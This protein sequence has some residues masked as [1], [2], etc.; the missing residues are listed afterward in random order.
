MSKPFKHFGALRNG[1]GFGIAIDDLDPI[2]TQEINQT[3]RDLK[4]NIDGVKFHPKFYPRNG[5]MLNAWVLPARPDVIPPMLEI[6]ERYEFKR[7]GSAERLISDVLKAEAD[8]N[9]ERAVNRQL[10]SAHDGPDVYV[11]GFVGEIRNYQRAAIDWII[12]HR[13][14]YIGDEMGTGKTL[15]ALAAVAADGSYP[16]VVVAPASVKLGWHRQ[17]Q[18]FF[19]SLVGQT[20]VCNGRLAKPIPQGT[21]IILINYDILSF[22]LT[23]LQNFKY[24]AVVLDEAHF[25][26]NRKAKRSRAAIVLAQGAEMRIAMSGTPLVSRPIDLVA[27]L[28]AL[29]RMES[30]TN[31]R[32][33]WWFIE[34]YCRPTHNGYGWDT[35][36]A[37]NLFELNERLRRNGILIRRRKEDVLTEMPPKQRVSIPL[38]ISN[39]KE[40][41]RVRN[42]ISHWVKKQIGLDDKFQSYLSGLPKKQAESEL[43]QRINE[44]ILKAEAAVTITK[45][46]ALRQVCMLGK[47]DAAMQW[48]DDFLSSEEKLVLFVS[49]RSAVDTVMSRFGSAAV[50]IMGGMGAEAKQKAIDSFINDDEVRV[51]VANIDAAA[52][53]IDGWQHVC[54]N[55]AFLE[56]T[57]TPTKH[58]QAE[59]RCHRSGQTKP[60]TC[61]YLMAN[62]TIDEYLA[63]IIDNKRSVISAVVDGEKTE[64]SDNILADLMRRLTQGE[65]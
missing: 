47:I 35:S 24:K 36:G 18:K 21:K 31:G 42:D 8:A 16:V 33:T 11:P 37:S 12:R 44:K 25:V 54:S 3:L 39:R 53:G 15:S 34:R 19:P 41:E 50:K 20:Y 48:V 17:I 7:T 27:Q 49:H 22:W 38:E 26:K 4:A 60:V 46:S 63:A 61:Y 14:V 32:R 1:S 57:W 9:E 59:D 51:V 45:L 29:G 58:H 64:R 2:E 56:L 40:Y 23:R 10:S 65:F 28:E 55:V 6:V 62:G 30:L 5:K 43:T 13:K 52:E